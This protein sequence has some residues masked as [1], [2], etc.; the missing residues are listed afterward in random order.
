M[1]PLL[2]VSGLS[3]KAALGQLRLINDP[4]QKSEKMDLDAPESGFLA[5]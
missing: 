2:P 5:S 3:R 1:K 4:F